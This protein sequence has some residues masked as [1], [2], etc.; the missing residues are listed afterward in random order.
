VNWSYLRRALL[1]AA[2]LAF[3]LACYVC[4]SI[5]GFKLLVA[6]ATVV[7]FSYWS[8]VRRLE[9]SDRPRQTK[10]FS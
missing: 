7:L 1:Y 9:K 2:L 3:V 4:S 6:L 8:E 5:D 10:R